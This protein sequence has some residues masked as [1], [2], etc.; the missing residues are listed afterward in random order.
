ML[1]C[2]TAPAHTS[3]AGGRKALAGDP[4]AGSG[5]VLG[6][7]SR[8]AA[9]TRTAV[10]LGRWADSLSSLEARIAAKVEFR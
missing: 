2:G 10:A 4:S 1:L 7:P 3:G 9:A 6:P 5:L 8:R